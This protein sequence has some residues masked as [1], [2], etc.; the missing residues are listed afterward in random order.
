[1][2]QLSHKLYSREMPIQKRG[3]EQP[4]KKMTK[5]ALI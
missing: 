1:M 5:N 4:G 2:F 3:R